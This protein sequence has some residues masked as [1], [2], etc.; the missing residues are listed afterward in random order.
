MEY[1]K[2]N[3]IQIYNAKDVYSIPIAEYVV[4]GILNLYKNAFYFR[5]NQE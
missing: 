1:V 4:M 2:E 3:N 5:E